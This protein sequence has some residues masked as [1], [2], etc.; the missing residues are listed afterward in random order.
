MTTRTAPQFGDAW[1]YTKGRTE[2]PALSLDFG[3]EPF[4]LTREVAPAQDHAPRE[5]AP[6]QT[7][8]DLFT[9]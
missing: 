1:K 5:T 2:A 7:H 3:A 8:P 6:A 9:L 4:Q